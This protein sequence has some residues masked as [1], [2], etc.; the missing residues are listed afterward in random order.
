MLIAHHLAR[1]PMLAPCDVSVMAGDIVGLIGP[2]GAGK[3]S[4]LRAL[5]G[6]SEGP[7]DVTMAGMALAHVARADRPG[8]FAYMPAERHVD[9]PM[10]VR[11]LVALG[12]PQPDAD[13]PAVQ[14][15]LRR[16]DMLA[17]A[18]KSVDKLSTGER[19]R[20]LLARALVAKP[21]YILLDEPI[22]N[23]DPYYQLRILNLLRAEAARGAAIIMAMHDLQ[24]A[25]QYCDRLILMQRGTIL[26][27]G[28]AQTLLTPALL[29]QAFQI[30]NGPQGWRA[31]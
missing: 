12:L 20:V 23:L 5:A 3:T 31:L 8:L 30:E 9:W 25:S 17:F 13:A 10:Q 16:T 28:P 1:P 14:D 22:A 19:A 7:G 11:D 26:A 15:I 29:A 6:I 27:Q 2:N 4:L 21:R 18:H 24:M